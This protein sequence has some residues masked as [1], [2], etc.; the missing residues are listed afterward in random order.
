MS[1]HDQSVRFYR[2]LLKLAAG[3]RLDLM[4]LANYKITRRPIGLAMC[5][6][7]IPGR[8]DVLFLTDRQRWSVVYIYAAT[9][10]LAGQTIVGIL[11]MARRT[12]GPAYLSM[13]IL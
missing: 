5:W 2:S 9:L 7:F 6:G 3:P 10:S 11:S 1:S 12:S 8:V 4:R 13:E